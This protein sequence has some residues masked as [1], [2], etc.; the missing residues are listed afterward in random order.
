[1]KG[2]LIKDIRMI[3]KN[4]RTAL[5]FLIVCAVMS[6]T[7]DS[8]FMIG[9]IGLLLGIMG[10]GTVNQDEAL[11]G[12]PFLFSLPVDRK[13]YVKE[14]FLFCLGLETLSMLISTGLFAI[15]CLFRQDPQ[16]LTEGLPVLLAMIPVMAIAISAMITLELKYGTEKSRYMLMLIYGGIAALCVLIVKLPAHLTA[17]LRAFFL[18][19]VT[20]PAPVLIAG[21]LLFCFLIIA[22]LF[23]VSIRV[24]EKKEF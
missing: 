10:L 7:M 17:G 3:L 2:L 13:T 4:K 6:F 23:S 1:M 19:I 22:I 9:Y 12:Y 18:K 11:N 5:A 15:V 8:S 16:D 21:M 20:L 14:K 24:M